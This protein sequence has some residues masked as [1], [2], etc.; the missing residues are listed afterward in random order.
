MVIG[1]YLHSKTNTHS[2]EVAPCWLH[3]LPCVHSVG[4]RILEST[5]V[6][7]PTKVQTDLFLMPWP[8]LISWFTVNCDRAARNHAASLWSGWT[9][10]VGFKAVHCSELGLVWPTAS[11]WY[12]VLWKWCDISSSFMSKTYSIHTSFWV[13]AHIFCLWVPSISAC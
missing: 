13:R 2:A 8:K 6:P 5:H 12:E 9:A 7:E 10:G 3:P 1:L 4:G 11:L